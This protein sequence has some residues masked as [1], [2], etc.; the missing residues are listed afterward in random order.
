MIATET[1]AKYRY[2]NRS[3]FGRKKSQKQKKRLKNIKKYKFA[4]RRNKN[5]KNKRIRFKNRFNQHKFLTQWTQNAYS[6]YNLYQILDNIHLPPTN[7]SNNSARNL[8]IT[9]SLHEGP[10][11]EQTVFQNFIHQSLQDYDD[12]YDNND[13]MRIT[14]AQYLV[15]IMD[16]T[17]LSLSDISDPPL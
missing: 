7:F 12:S 13:P 8:N 3:T 16:V 11:P 1:I 2:R 10:R 17:S 5:R 6:H 14:N 4:S 15:N 9:S